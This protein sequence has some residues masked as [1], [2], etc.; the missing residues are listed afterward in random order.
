MVEIFSGLKLTLTLSSCMDCA[1]LILGPLFALSKRRLLGK[2]ILICA[3]TALF[4]GF[5]SNG[6]TPL[7]FNSLV[8]MRINAS[9]LAMAYTET[10]IS[11]AHETTAHRAES[12]CMVSLAS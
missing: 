6:A 12:V 11:P 1:L 5:H 8:R 9:R 2:A 10:R 7:V 4:F 3:H